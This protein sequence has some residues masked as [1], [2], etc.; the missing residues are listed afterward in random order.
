[1]AGIV[2]V[3]IAMEAG[4]LHTGYR[5][6]RVATPSLLGAEGTRLRGHEFHF[7]RV[8]SGAECLNPA[9]SMHDSEGEPL[10]CEGWTS[11]NLVASFVHLHFGQDEQLATRLVAAARTAAA[12][13]RSLVGE[14]G[15]AALV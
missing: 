7:S 11:G 1:M 13:R 4:E 9:Y 14:R 12:D 5:D 6:L 10:G 15:S 8:I 3:D 2:P